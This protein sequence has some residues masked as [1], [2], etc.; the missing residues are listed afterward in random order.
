MALATPEIVSGESPLFETVRLPGEP[1]PAPH[2]EA[3]AIG[4]ADQAAT[5]TAPVAVRLIVGGATEQRASVV[6]T[7]S[8]P[9]SPLL[10]EGTKV[11]F[12]GA[13]PLFAAAVDPDVNAAE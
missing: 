4:V 13:V 3:R 5:G 8:V 1:A 12:P 7:L 10:V 2:V 9:L 6:V 11:T